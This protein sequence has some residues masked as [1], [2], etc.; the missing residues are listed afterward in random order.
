MTTTI[1]SSEISIHAVRV[2]TYLEACG[3]KWATAADVAS[4]A[5]VAPRTARMYVKRLVDLGIADLAEVFPAHRYRVSGKAKQRN[6]GYW[7][8]LKEAQTIFDL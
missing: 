6:R 7:N 8:R 5:Q 3:Q 2:Y 1:E 4:G